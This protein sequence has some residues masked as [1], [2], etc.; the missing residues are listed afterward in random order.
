MN[1]I[2]KISSVKII[3]NPELPLI[4]GEF[5]LPVKFEYNKSH[6]TE[7]EAIHIAIEQIKLPKGLRACIADAEQYR[8]SQNNKVLMQIGIDLFTK[9]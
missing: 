5:D 3:Q 2:L 9:H 7:Q 8:L 1:K 4:K 6:V